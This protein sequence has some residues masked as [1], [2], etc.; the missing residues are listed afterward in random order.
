MK[1]EYWSVHIAQHTTNPPQLELWHDPSKRWVYRFLDLR[2]FVNSLPMQCCRDELVPILTK[3]DYQALCCAVT[4]LEP[5]AMLTLYIMEMEHPIMRPRFLCHFGVIYRV[6]F[7]TIWKTCWTASRIDLESLP[8]Y[9]AQPLANLITDILSCLENHFFS[10]VSHETKL[11]FALSK[12]PSLQFGMGMEPPQEIADFKANTFHGL[13][14]PDPL[15]HYDLPAVLHRVEAKL[16]RAKTFQQIDE[17]TDSSDD[18]SWKTRVAPPAPPPNP[19][20]PFFS[21]NTPTNIIDCMDPFKYTWQRIYGR[22]RATSSK[23]AARS[24][25]SDAPPQP[26]R[27]PTWTTQSL[28]GW[29][30]RFANRYFQEWEDWTDTYTLLMGALQSNEDSP[31]VRGELSEEVCSFLHVTCDD[32]ALDWC[33]SVES[34]SM[35]HIRQLILDLHTIPI[36]NEQSYDDEEDT[37]E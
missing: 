11:A 31:G 18:E 23:A 19:H 26:H 17:G 3:D 20:P 14:D 29:L 1:S 10:D 25:A 36:T 30:G 4:V 34:E 7:D 2:H 27:R 12:G 6:I 8:S 32:T 13:N 37:D 16:Q 28:R 21:R 9:H 24:L 5:L 15:L 33:S 35:P 22:G